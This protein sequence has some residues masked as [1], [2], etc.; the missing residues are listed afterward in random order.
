[1]S[2]KNSF[3]SATSGSTEVDIRKEFF[4][5]MYGHGPEIPKSQSGLLRVFRRN[6]LLNLIPCP[7]VDAV[8]G[9]P[10]RETRCPICLGEGNLWDETSI[11][12]YHIKASGQSSLALQ[13]RLRAPGI[14]N[15]EVEVFY[16]PW[17]FNLTKDD[18]IVVLRLD[19]EGSSTTPPTRFQLFRISEVRPMRL[20]NG[21]LE[22]WKIYTYEDSSKFL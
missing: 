13:D 5:T 7:C 8:T 16:I 12:F 11:D 14:M 3:Y 2:G 17:Q 4:H 10:D 18:K 21:R 15:T 19:K 22:F 1:M 9:E 20:D 6:S